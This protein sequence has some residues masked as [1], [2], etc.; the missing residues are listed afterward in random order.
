M[1]NYFPKRPS[2]APLHTLSK[3]YVIPVGFVTSLFWRYVLLYLR[4]PKVC[5]CSISDDLSCSC[6]LPTSCLVANKAFKGLFPPLPVCC[7]CPHFVPGS[8]ACFV[9]FLLYRSSPRCF[10]FPPLRFPSGVHFSAIFQSMFLSCLMIS[11]IIFHLRHFISSL[12][13]F[14]RALS[15][16]SSIPT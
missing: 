4:L 14:I 6:Y 7:Y 1:R 3:L 15:N 11:P 10:W 12:S 9:P 13:G 8:P 5:C 16:S 2:G